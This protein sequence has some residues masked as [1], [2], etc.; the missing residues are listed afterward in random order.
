[1]DFRLTPAPEALASAARRFATETAPRPC[2]AP[3]KRRCGGAARHQ[4]LANARYPTVHRRRRSAACPQE[5]VGS[6]VGR[7]GTSLIMTNSSDTIRSV[8][9]SFFTA[10]LGKGTFAAIQ[11][12][13]SR[14][15]NSPPAT[16]R[17]LTLSAQP[18][19]SRTA[20]SAGCIWT[21]PTGDQSGRP[22]TA[23]PTV[24]A[25]TR[26]DAGPKSIRRVSVS[27]TAS[28]GKGSGIG[29]QM[30][31]DFPPEIAH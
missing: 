17:Q 19:S 29:N 14:A 18:Y 3:R 24:S 7:G 22:S 21:A 9:W 27:A 10:L 31:C 5:C 25:A 1:M 26:I 12:E 2:P 20:S 8:T 4:A 23:T 30:T 6:R 28:D 16:I 13:I 15:A 11:Y